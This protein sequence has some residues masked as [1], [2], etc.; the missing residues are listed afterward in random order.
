MSATIEPGAADQ[1]PQSLSLERLLPP[2]PVCRHRLPFQPQLVGDFVDECVHL[3]RRHLLVT[4]PRERVA[5]RASAR[6][7]REHGEG[8]AGHAGKHA[9]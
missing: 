6:S 9:A 3:L 4:D 1:D 8:G 7:K 5:A 2:R